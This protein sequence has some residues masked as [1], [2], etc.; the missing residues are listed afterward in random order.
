MK[1][2]FSECSERKL[3]ADGIAD[4]ITGRKEKSNTRDTSSECTRAYKDGG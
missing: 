2:R 1:K 3:S 4:G